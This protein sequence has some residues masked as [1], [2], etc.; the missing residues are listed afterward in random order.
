MAIKTIL[1]IFY[2]TSK[3]TWT[4][5]TKPTTVILENCLRTLVYDHQSR[6]DMEGLIY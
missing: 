4:L 2:K 5:T 3:S 1:R 6:I